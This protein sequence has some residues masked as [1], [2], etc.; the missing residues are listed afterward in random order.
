MSSKI[1]LKYHRSTTSY[2]WKQSQSN[3]ES[4]GLQQ[5]QPD[6]FR[7]ENLG[8]NNKITYKK[9]REVQ[10]TAITS[11]AKEQRKGALSIL[12]KMS[13][14]T[15]CNKENWTDEKHVTFAKGV[16]FWQSENVL[17]IIPY[18]NLSQSIHFLYQSKKL[19]NQ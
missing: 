19:I 3:S 5:L 2:P 1:L 17:K 18:I 13:R 10:R 16:I 6:K 14:R 7:K 11:M 8:L 12:C 15:W 4:H 9:K